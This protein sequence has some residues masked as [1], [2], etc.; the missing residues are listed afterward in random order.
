[1]TNVGGGSEARS[2]VNREASASAMDALY[3]L[4]CRHRRI[5]VLSGAGISTASGIPDYRDAQGEWKRS[6][7][8]DHRDFM[9]RHASRQRYWARAMI[10][11][12]VLNEASP[13]AAHRA[14]AELELRGK[15]SG[16]ITQNVDGLHQR[17]GSRRVIDL[18]GRAD[19]VVCM[20]CGARQMRHALHDEL[21]RC[22]PQW[23]AQTSPVRPAP[24]GD[25]DL[26]A[27]FSSFRVPSCGRCGDGI[28]KP[29]VVFFGDNVPAA[30]LASARGL[31]EDSDALLVVGS[32]LMVYSGF[33]FVRESVKAGR[34]VACIN[35]GR[36][37]A[38]EL[39]DVKLEAPAVQALEALVRDLG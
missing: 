36:T 14:I 27:D 3:A 12:R 13:N 7:P 26:E 11:F 29:D 9:S 16:V 6:P 19:L 31:L 23:V 30:T 21:A 34:P 28:W 15:V 32:S 35:L 38:D 1:M 24:D 8:I 37:R 20:S 18:H 17:A 4:V 33:R 39:F 2:C 5:A 10:G 22:N 25:A